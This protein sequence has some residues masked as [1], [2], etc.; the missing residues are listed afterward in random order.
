MITR[1]Q[2]K[3]LWNYWG[4]DSL[5][6]IVSVAAILPSFRICV[7]FQLNAKS[8]MTNFQKIFFRDIL[9]TQFDDWIQKNDITTPFALNISKFIFQVHLRIMKFWFSFQSLSSIERNIMRNVQ[10]YR[11]R[12]DIVISADSSDYQHFNSSN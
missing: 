11:F 1:Y 5:I 10:I 7:C 6:Q 8:V 2:N 3:Y 4:N 9:W 12:V